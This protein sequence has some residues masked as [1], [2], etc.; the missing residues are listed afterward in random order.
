VVSNPD[1]FIGYFNLPNPSSR[2]MTLGSTEALTEM[3]T[4]NCPG[5]KWRPARPALLY[6]RKTELSERVYYNTRANCELFGVFTVS[7]FSVCS[8]KTECHQRSVRCFYRTRS[9]AVQWEHSHVKCIA[10]MVYD[11]IT[12]SAN[13]RVGVVVNEVLGWQ[14]HCHLWADYLENVGASMS[15]SPRASKAWYRDSFNY[16]YFLFFNAFKWPRH[17]S[18]G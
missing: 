12:D 16:K 14:P 5:G 7:S 13:N 4:R 11:K 15:H 1:E 3:S 10:T 6:G 17:S 9:T 8:D 2:I 18:G